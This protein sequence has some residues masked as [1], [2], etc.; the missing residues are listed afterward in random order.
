[1][2]LKAMLMNISFLAVLIDGLF[3][4]LQNTQINFSYYFIGGKLIYFQ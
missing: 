2:N 1:M 4:V 3:S